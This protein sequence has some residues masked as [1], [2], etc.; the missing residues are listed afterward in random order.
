MPAETIIIWLVVGAVVGLLAG[1]IVK[2]GGFGLLGDIVVGILGAFVGGLLLPRF[3]VHVV[4]G[5][6]GV[7]ASARSERSWCCSFRDWCETPDATGCQ[8][9][10]AASAAPAIRAP[11]RRS[12]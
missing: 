3:G 12:A 4:A 1:L 9:D 2:G 6:I 7:I 11:D 5:L 8:H 10:L